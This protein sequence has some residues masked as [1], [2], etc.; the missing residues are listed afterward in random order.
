MKKGIKK[1]LGICHAVMWLISIYLCGR[2]VF[3]FSRTIFGIIPLYFIAVVLS[4]ICISTKSDFQSEP[5]SPHAKCFSIIALIIAI[6]INLVSVL[7]LLEYDYADNYGFLHDEE[8]IFASVKAT[9][10]QTMCY[11]F[12]CLFVILLPKKYMETRLV[13]LS[14]IAAVYIMFAVISSC[15]LLVCKDSFISGPWIKYSNYTFRCQVV[16]VFFIPVFLI[17]RI[18]LNIRQNELYE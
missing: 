11:S 15:Y 9:A 17:S 5:A 16:C 6:L 3:G 10:F 2:V 12:I 14:K 4:A 18:V 13:L 7:I 1:E 8:T